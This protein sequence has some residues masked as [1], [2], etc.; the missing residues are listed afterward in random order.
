MVLLLG[1]Y[2][3]GKQEHSQFLSLVTS[4]TH[5]PGLALSTSF[6]ERRVS[7]YQDQ[8][9]RLYPQMRYYKEMDYVYAK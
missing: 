5:L 9:N 3:Q 7:E 6:L 4:L 8:S 2:P 1:V